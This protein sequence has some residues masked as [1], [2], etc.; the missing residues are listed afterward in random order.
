MKIVRKVKYALRFLPDVAY[1]QLYYLAKFKRFCNLKNPQTFNEKIQWLKLHD[2]KP[3][4]IR[5]VDK[6]DA[7]QYIADIIGSEYV[8][9]TYGVWEKFEDIDFGK[10]PSQFVL[11]C[12]HDSGGYFICRDKDRLNYKEAQTKINESLKHNFFWEGREWPYKSVR[13]RIIAEKLLINKDNSVVSDYKFYCFDGEVYSVNVTFGRGTSEG[14]RVNTL[15]KNFKP[16]DISC[17]NYSQYDGEIVK[18]LN[19][20]KMLDIAATL[21]K[22]IAFARIDLYNVEGQIYV[23]EITLYP[24]SGFN[25]TMSKE[26]DKMLGSKIK[27]DI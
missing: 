27:L 8:I 12:T 10:L 14:L 22:G 11:K 26:Y 9:P 16:F 7:K 6:L 15:D 23:G 5:M 21:S 2:H 13:P 1:I 17:L 3:E 20:E 25:T 19:Y 24:G 18:P 4:Y